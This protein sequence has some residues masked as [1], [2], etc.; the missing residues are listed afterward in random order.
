MGVS[1]YILTFNDLEKVKGCWKKTEVMKRKT[2]MANLE[3]LIRANCLVGAGSNGQ[4]FRSQLDTAFFTD[5][6][7]TGIP[8]S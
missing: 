4:P 1:T 5:T 7:E 2:I 6:Q 8:L 3:L